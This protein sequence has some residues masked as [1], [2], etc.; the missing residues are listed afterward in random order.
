MPSPPRSYNLNPESELALVRQLLVDPAVL[1]RLAQHLRP[2]GFEQEAVR[3]V[4]AGALA[5]FK[6]AKAIPR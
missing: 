4:V 5:Y 6:V 3:D 1:S 2:E